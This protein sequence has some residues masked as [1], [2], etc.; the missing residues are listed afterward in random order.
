[1]EQP[2]MKICFYSPY[3]PGHF[4]GGEKHFLDTALAASKNHL[5][6]IT[7]PVS[8]NIEVIQKQYSQ[9]MGKTLSNLQFVAGPLQTGSVVQ[10]LLFTKAFDA[11][12]Y[13]TDG[14]FFLTATAHRFLH[15]QIPFKNTLNFW[16]QLKLLH[17][18]NKNTNS[19]FTKRVVEQAWSTHI[20]VIHYPQVFIPKRSS[21]KKD[22][23][24]LAVGRFF[25]HLHAKRQDILV[26][27]FRMFCERYPK[28]SNGWKLVLIGNVENEAYY[29]EVTEMARGLR[30]ELYR[31]CSREELEHW[32]KKATL[33]WHAS[34]YDIDEQRH[35]ENV[36]HFGITTLEAM[37][38]GVVPIV[39]KKGGQPEVL[40]EPL[41]QYLW[42]SMEECVALTAQLIR[43]KALLESATKHSIEQAKKFDSTLFEKRVEKLFTL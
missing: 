20:D 35:P 32:Y 24:I 26:K 28:E 13:V 37:A 18:S 7:V 8:T 19:L 6:T 27:I 22:K 38:H 11:L 43:D 41:K 21:E 12:Y 1:M 15:I 2:G 14:S 9:F 10:K 23:T 39:H 42:N 33:F 30:I 5:V 34:G 16:Q 29:S 4:G 3:L 25:T 36:E 40:G 17:W 31:D